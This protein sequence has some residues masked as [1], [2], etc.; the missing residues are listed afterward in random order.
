MC[1]L[2]SFPSRKKKE[3]PLK[4]AAPKLEGKRDQQKQIHARRKR[5]R[6]KKETNREHEAKEQFRRKKV[7][8]SS[9]GARHSTEVTGPLGLT[10]TH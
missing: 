9:M 1:L 5:W 10:A 3:M 8:V 6:G 4:P 7:N 2:F